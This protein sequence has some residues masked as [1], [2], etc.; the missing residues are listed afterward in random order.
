MN[1]R[2]MSTRY[3]GTRTGRM[4]RPTRR[5]AYQLRWTPSLNSPMSCRYEVLNVK[6]TA[7]SDLLAADRAEHPL[8]PHGEHDEEDHVRRHVLE[9]G[10]RYVPEN[11]SITPMVT[12][13]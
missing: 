12:P 2:L 7:P 6:R 5:A 4:S 10:G 8:R 13:P 3:E 11:S 9:A 1:T